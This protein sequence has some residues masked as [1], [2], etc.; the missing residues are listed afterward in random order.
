MNKLP[1]DFCIIIGGQKCGTSTLYQHLADHSKICPCYKKE[2]HIFAKSKYLLNV[3]KYKRMW[4]KNWKPK[5]HKIAIEAS[6]SYTNYPIRTD[7]NTQK[8]AKR[9]YE[10]KKYSKANVKLIFI[11]RDP[12]ERIES[13]VLKEYIHGKHYGRKKLSKLNNNVDD[14]YLQFTNYFKIINNYRKYFDKNDFLIIN[15]EDLILRRKKV[16]K[17]C[18]NFLNLD[19]EYGGKSYHYQNSSTRIKKI[20][21][22]NK[23]IRG[24]TVNDIMSWELSHKQRLRIYQSLRSDMRKMSMTYGVNIMNW[25]FYKYY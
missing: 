24:M 1:N 19:F 12:F 16:L 21:K 17:K 4:A 2:P 25:D 5:R 11:I 22:K 10:F 14:K 20:F 6:T 13:F 23:Q 8:V 15:F 9:I 18:F 7:V 3:D